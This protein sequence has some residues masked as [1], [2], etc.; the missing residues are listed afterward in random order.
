MPGHV[1]LHT[2]QAV[3]KRGCRW[4]DLVFWIWEK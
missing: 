4:G 3:A 2:E 1:T